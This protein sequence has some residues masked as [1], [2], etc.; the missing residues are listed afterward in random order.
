MRSILIHKDP[1]S[2]YGVTVPDL[3]GCF[4]GGDTLDEAVAMAHEAITGHLETML[5]EGLGLPVPELRSLQEHQA[6]P[7]FADGIWTLVEVDISKISVE[8][9]QV[10]IEFPEPVIAMIDDIATKERETRSELLTRSVLSHID[11]QTVA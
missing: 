8:M 3:R 6:N 11:R 2:D 10:S 7:D 5:I 4:S 9:V 1:D